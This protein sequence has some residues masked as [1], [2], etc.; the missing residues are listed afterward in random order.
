[1]NLSFVNFFTTL[2]KTFSLW[3]SLAQKTNP[4]FLCSGNPSNLGQLLL[5]KL[6]LKVENLCFGLITGAANRPGFSLKNCVWNRL[7]WHGLNKSVCICVCVW[8]SSSKTPNL[9]GFKS[10]WQQVAHFFCPDWGPQRA[11]LSTKS[12]ATKFLSRWMSQL[13]Q[14]YVEIEL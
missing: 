13:R 9:L 3:I 4:C 11:E 14:I 12:K 2:L 7:V 1:M 10:R 6:I 5:F 8:Q